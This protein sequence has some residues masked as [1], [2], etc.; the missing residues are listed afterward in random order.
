MRKFNCAKCEKMFDK[1]YELERHWRMPHFEKKKGFTETP[2]ASR[3][4][5]ITQFEFSLV[6]AFCHN[7]LS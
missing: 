4:F 3:G 7:F 1:N 2:L 6:G 5:V